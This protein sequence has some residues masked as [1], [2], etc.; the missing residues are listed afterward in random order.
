MGHRSVRS[1]DILP[2]NGHAN[3]TSAK[4]RRRDLDRSDR[5]LAWNVPA[6][7]ARSPEERQ[8]GVAEFRWSIADT[9]TDANANTNT[10]ANTDADANADANTNANTNADT[11][12]DANPDANAD[13][14]AD[15]DADANADTASR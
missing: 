4:S 11:N 5:A 10:D 6:H 9:D 15:A 2:I 13:A 12:A 14:D 1:A 8:H 7:V 3:H